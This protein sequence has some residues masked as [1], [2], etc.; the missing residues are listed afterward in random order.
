MAGSTYTSKSIPLGTKSFSG[1]LNSTSGEL[2]V[3]DNE[4]SDLSNI[5]FNKFGSILKRN[6]YLNVNTTATGAYGSDGLYWYEY[7]SSGLLK[8]VAV[9]VSN[10]VIYAM[11][12]ADGT[13]HDI[14]GSLTSTPGTYHD[15]TTWLNRMYGTNGVDR[16]WTWN[17]TGNASVLTA[18]TANS[19]TFIVTGVTTAPVAG[20]TYTNNTITYTVVASYI[21]SGSGTIVAT[22]SGSPETAGNLTH[23]SGGTGDATIAFSAFT[24]NANIANAK[25]I[26]QFSNYLF[27]ANVT[28]GSTYYP[29]RIYYSALKDDTQ[30]SAANYLEVSKD[31]GQEI[32]GIRV[33]SDRLVVYKTRSIYTVFYTGD[34]DIP[35]I[36]PGGGKANSPVGCVA[37][38]SIQEVD[39]GHVF[40]ALD[41]LYFFDSSN[42]YKL[43]YRLDTTFAGLNQGG[44]NR[45]RS[46]VQ[47][48]KNRYWLAVSNG[49]SGTNNMVIVW[50]FYNNAFSLYNG[51]NASAMR[52]IYLTSSEERPHFVDYAGWLYRADYGTDDYV[53][54]TGTTVTKTAIDAYYYTNWKS[55]DDLCDQKGVA[56]VYIYYQLNTATLSFS[57]SYNFAGTDEYTSGIDTTGTVIRWEAFNWGEGNWSYRGGSV[58]RRDLTG[59]GRVVRFKFANREVGQTF[60]IDGF[61]AL[62]HLETAV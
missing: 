28:V 20:E 3:Q 23:T 39:N 5:D 33:L 29:T 25:Y 61:G 9:N 35:F 16:P 4:S 56:H 49:S 38:F 51:I 37:P 6:G 26:S 55:F 45:V 17:G 54:S 43:S 58:S 42:S 21:S 48:I 22:G 52:T 8:Q 57:Y 15:F 18:L 50:D 40:L 32:T 10:A 12:D 46:L 30:W 19:Y 11:H 53:G 62:T 24:I 36:L 44:F 60:R 31:D 7:F 1:G 13:Y 27:L 59:R 14:T 41:G 34:V 47:K 2:G